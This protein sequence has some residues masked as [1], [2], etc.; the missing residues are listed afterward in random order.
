MGG[1]GGDGG[2]ISTGVL[3]V[4][5]RPGN[6]LRSCV[7]RL[8]P[9]V[10]LATLLDGS[11]VPRAVMMV[12]AEREVRVT[13]V[14]EPPIAARPVETKLE[15]ETELMLLSGAYWRLTSSIAVAELCKARPRFSSTRAP[16]VLGGSLIKEE[17]C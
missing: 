16:A 7:L 6:W 9:S 4:M 3:T 12:A 10:M 13:L 1:G 5:A 17:G 15:R 2:I 8:L 14:T 11:G